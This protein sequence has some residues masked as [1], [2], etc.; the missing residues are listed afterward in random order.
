M[1]TKANVRK[2]K[3]VAK[4]LNKASKMH[5]SQARTLNKMIKKKK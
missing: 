4:A 5:A 2:V 1:K 3:K